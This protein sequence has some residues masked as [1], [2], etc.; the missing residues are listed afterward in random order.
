LAIAHTKYHRHGAYLV[1]HSDMPGFSWQEQRS[2]A[3]LVRGHRRRFPNEVFDSLSKEQR[4]L[5]R[6]LTVLLRLAVLL[7]RGRGEIELPRFHITARKREFIVRFPRGWLAR[8]PLTLADLAQEAKY[9][10]SARY[11]LEFS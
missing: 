7:H 5:A 3:A 2:I 9:L 8:N 10:K 1:E 11:R 4:R 6:R